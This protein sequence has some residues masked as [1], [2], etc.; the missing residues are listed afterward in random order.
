MTPQ[1][2]TDDA[3]TAAI[4]RV[5]DVPAQYLFL[6]HS[7]PEHLMRWF[8]PVGYPVMHCECDFRVG[9]AWRMQM[10]GPDGVP[11]PFF[12]GT[13]LEITPHSRIVYTNGFEDGADGMGLTTDR[14]RM[15]MTTTFAEAGGKTTLIVSILFATAAMR[16]EFLGIGMLEGLSSGL[17]Q[18]D[19]VAKGLAQAG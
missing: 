19:G 7:R 11:G 17:D 10:T 18:L 2:D 12:G 6:A 4:S 14:H 8:G 16:Q 3:R 1:Q 15:V 5:M 13:Y 9:G